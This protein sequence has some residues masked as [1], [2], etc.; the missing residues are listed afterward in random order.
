VTPYVNV[1]AVFIDDTT[2]DLPLA[3]LEHQMEAWCAAGTEFLVVDSTGDLVAWSVRRRRG[4]EWEGHALPRREEPNPYI[5]SRGRCCA[6][7]ECCDQDEEG[8]T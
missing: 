5:D 1:R 7:P 3:G 2:L 8:T 4:L 6:D